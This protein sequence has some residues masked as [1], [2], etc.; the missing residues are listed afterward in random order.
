MNNKKALDE[1]YPVIEK[2]KGLW[3]YRIEL[4]FDEKGKRIQ[5]TS[6]RQKFT[7]KTARIAAL[8][9][10][11]NLMENDGIIPSKSDYTIN[12]L[13]DMYIKDYL[14]KHEGIL[15]PSS[16]QNRISYNNKVKKDLGNYYVGKISVETYQKYL[17]DLHDQGYSEHYR[18]AINVQV[19]LIF[20]YARVLGIRSDNITKKALV[21]HPNIIAKD[22]IKF[23]ANFFEYDELCRFLNYAKEHAHFRHY[24]AYT[25]LAHTGMR[26]GEL[27]ALEWKDIDFK[28]KT[29]KIYKTIYHENDRTDDFLLL[30]PKT[31]KSK[32]IVPIRDDEV[33]LLIELKEQQ[34]TE[35]K[36]RNKKVKALDSDFIFTNLVYLGYPLNTGALAYHFRKIILKGKFNPKITPHK[37][38][39]THISILAEAGASLSEI[40][41]RVGHGEGRTT[42]QIYLHY[43]DFV[44]SNALDIYDKHTSKLE[45]EMLE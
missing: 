7:K 44:K 8:D 17:N 5:K 36:T 31:S 9:F 42:E 15:K 41:S 18:Q 25:L 26:P 4:G 21:I 22:N 34:M 2:R 16:I 38:R 45:D 20:E 39:H 37:L 29:I 43:T 27:L 40:K 12:E 28:K 32:R 13:A 14:K 10:I 35:W 23:D 30:T 11:A 19:K 1:I 6:F 24:V 33:E 3:G